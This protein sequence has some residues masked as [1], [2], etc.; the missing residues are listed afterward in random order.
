MPL[1]DARMFEWSKAEAFS[2]RIEQIC[3]KIPLRGAWEPNNRIA[4]AMASFKLAQ[5]HQ[6][7]MHL[8]TRHARHASANALARPLLE[9]ALRTIWF[10][11]DATQDEIAAISKGRNSAVPLLGDLV[12]RLGRRSE[13]VVSGKHRGLLDSLT[14]GGVVALGAQ[15]LMGEELDR[16]KAAMLAYGAVAV[17]SAAYTVAQ[18]IECQEPLAELTEILSPFE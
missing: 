15:F 12:R 1:D 11:E 5:E 4:F 8:L 7:S 10:I 9:A 14:H 6:F 3:G 17:A 16:S 18:L 2:L 13:L